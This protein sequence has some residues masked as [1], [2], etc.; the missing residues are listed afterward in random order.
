MKKSRIEKLIPI[1]NKAL[2]EQNDEMLTKYDRELNE[3]KK[4]EISETSLLIK[5]KGDTYH[6]K[7]NYDGKVSG[8]GISVALSGLLPTIAMYFND[9]GEVKTKPVLELIAK[10][11][12]KDKEYKLL[13][14]ATA[15]GLLEHA[16]TFEKNEAG[17]KVLKK[18]V[19]EA[20]IALKQ[21]V[22]TYEL[23]D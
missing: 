11:I 22:R 4:K 13:S 8:F 17:L 9:S 10:I 15:K 3:K 1:A 20:A 6:I 19:L 16:L 18:Y 5:E 12:L 21:I 7:S 23:K 14:D 2:L